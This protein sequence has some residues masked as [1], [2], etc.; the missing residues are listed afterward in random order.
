MA[1]IGVAQVLVPNNDHV[2]IADFFEGAKAQGL[3]IKLND[4]HAAAP[5]ITG[6]KVEQ[7][8]K[9]GRIL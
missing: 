8:E 1:L 7:E 4:N 9:S 2:S 5:T 3:D 6:K